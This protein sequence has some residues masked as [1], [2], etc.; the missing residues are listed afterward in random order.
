MAKK[1]TFSNKPAANAP[2]NVE[3]PTEKDFEFDVL[4]GSKAMAFKKINYILLLIGVVAVVIGFL[5]M[6]GSSSS[7]KAFEPD[8]FSVRR[9]TVAPLIALAGFVFVIFAILY[10]KKQKR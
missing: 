3:Q 9:T 2:T 6:T 10:H 1:A 5:L 7:T 4:D 8:I